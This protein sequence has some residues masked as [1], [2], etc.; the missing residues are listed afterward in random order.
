MCLIADNLRGQDVRTSA[1]KLG[2]TIAEAADKIG[3]T[4]WNTV[5]GCTDAIQPVDAGLGREVR[6]EIGRISGEWLDTGSNVDRWE[7]TDGSLGAGDRR[8]LM[9]QWAA[10]SWRRVT[11]K[12]KM[13]R[14][15]FERTGCHIATHVPC[16]R[17]S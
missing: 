16:P 4:I 12:D 3:V 1:G 15:M 8:I 14:R 7:G 11:Q 5:D 17:T 10:E 6:R 13:L 2:R 9:A